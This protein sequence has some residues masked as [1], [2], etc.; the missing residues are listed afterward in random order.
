MAHPDDFDENPC[1]TKL[2]GTILHLRRGEAQGARI[3]SPKQTTIPLKTI[4]PTSMFSLKWRRRLQRYALPRTPHAVFSLAYFYPRKSSCIRHHQQVF[5]FC[6]LKRPRPLWMLITLHSYVLWYL[7]FSW[8]EILRTLLRHSSALQKQKHINKTHQAFRL[9]NLALCHGIPPRF[10]YHYKLY[11]SHRNNWSHFVYTHELPYWHENMSPEISQQSKHLLRNKNTFFRCMKGRAI[12][13]IETLST[14]NS[15]TK[16]IDE[17]IFLRKSLFIKPKE[18]SRKQGC[19]KLTYVRDENV[20]QLSNGSLITR[21]K[22]E[23]LSIITSRSYATPYIIQPLLENSPKLNN[24]YTGNELI[25]VRWVTAYQKHNARSIAAAIEIPISWHKTRLMV[26]DINRGSLNPIEMDHA[27]TNV[28]T[29]EES[30][31]KKQMLKTTTLPNWEEI[32]KIAEKAHSYFND[33]ATI[34]WDF[35]ITPDGVK[36]LEGNFNWNV[37]P[38]QLCGRAL[39]NEWHHTAQSIREFDH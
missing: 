31:R 39:A 2:P 14:L 18:G 1:S 3:L 17:K 28:S 32:K 33:V 34:G 23:I 5:L 19:Y 29:D 20:Y 38:H 27:K 30:L 36:I 8:R 35:A 11:D 25:T 15:D 13:S 4:R 24:I 22:N 10:Y 9:L 7:F 6:L 37:T 21:K 16:Y 26:I 12:P